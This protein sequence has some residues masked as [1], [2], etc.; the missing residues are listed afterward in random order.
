MKKLYTLVLTTIIINLVTPAFSQVGINTDASDPDASSILDL[1]SSDKGLLIPRMTAAQRTA[2]T[3]PA[4]G[5]MIYQTDDADKGKGFY[6]YKGTAWDYLANLSRSIPSNV[7]LIKS[8]NDFPAPVAGVITLADNVT[9]QIN[10]TVYIGANTINFGVSNTIFGIDKSDDKLIYTGTG[11]MFTSSSQDFTIKVITVAAVAPGS[12]IFNVSGTGTK[13]QIQDNIFGN[14]KSLGTFDGGD[15]LVFDKNLIAYN[16]NGIEIKG[17]FEHLFFKDNVYEYNVA[18]TALTIPSG[19]FEVI[20][21]MGNYIDVGA[22]QTALDINPAISMEHGLISSNLFNGA[23]TFLS[24]VSPSTLKWIFQANVGVKDSDAYGFCRFWANTTVTSIGSKYPTYYKVSGTND[25]AYGER[26]DYSVNNRL[27]YTGVKNIT[28]KFIL[29]GNVE[30]TSSSENIMIAVV[31]NGTTIV[32]EVEI[33]TSNANQPYGMSVNGSVS[34]ST[35]DYLEIWVSN[36]T[37]YANVRIVDF[38]FRVEK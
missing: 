10:G 18:G 32:E 31:K 30:A 16:E 11:S 5:L 17:V 23:G 29:N 34:M 33:R 6:F 12:K 26:F 9:Y 24:G 15:I 14:S 27:T 22:G 35:N 20:H 3:S 25:G 7:V 8:V 13:I 1:K 4:E 19:T 21:I 36:I 38:Q 37:S 2:I 28:A